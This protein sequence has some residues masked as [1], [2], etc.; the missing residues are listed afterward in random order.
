M[1][2]ALNTAAHTAHHLATTLL[3]TSQV[4]P[5]STIP[6]APVKEAGATSQATNL[7]FKGK[8]IIVGVPG[9]FTNTC[10]QHIPGF[11]ENLEE[12]KKRGV[13]DIFIVA[14]NDVFVVKAWKEHL[15]SKFG[16]PV[17]FLADDEGRFVSGLGLLF[18]ATQNLGGPRSKRFVIVAQDDKV[19]H[20]AVE[21]DPSQ[22]T[23]TDAKRILTLL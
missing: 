14:V 18:D 17:R 15:S 19:E 21:E 4:K 1:S 12:F 10:N 11:L 7:D 20:I 2:S 6:A 22:V 8:N 13:S 16:T 5:G 9:A 3:A 23:V